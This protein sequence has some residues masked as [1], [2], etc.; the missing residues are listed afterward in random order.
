MNEIPPVSQEGGHEKTAEELAGDLA[1]TAWTVFLRNYEGHIKAGNM[2]IVE[3]DLGAE[4]DRDIALVKKEK[5][6]AMAGMMADRFIDEVKNCSVFVVESVERLTNEAKEK[7]LTE[8]T[9]E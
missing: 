4:I 5:G 6:V 7:Y 9:A 3:A 8:E 2:G 1:R